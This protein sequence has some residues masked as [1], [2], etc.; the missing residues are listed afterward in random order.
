MSEVVEI[1][2]PAKNA[3]LTLEQAQ[4]ITR[5]H[6]AEEIAEL[7][8]KNAQFIGENEAELE[9]YKGI[10]KELELRRE[11]LTVKLTKIIQGEGDELFDT[12]ALRGLQEIA[13]VPHW[14]AR[15][16][17][18]YGGGL[19]LSMP[20]DGC[21]V[22]EGGRMLCYLVRSWPD[23]TAYPAHQL[24]HLSTEDRNGLLKAGRKGA[25]AGLVVAATATDVNVVF[26]LPW[27]LLETA[28]PVKWTDP[29]LVALGSARDNIL[30]FTEI[31]PAR[32]HF[33]RGR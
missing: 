32:R 27:S 30:D 25:H 10:K 14:P 1:R 29:A 3:G 5:Y 24:E 20:Y 12:V 22:V 11:M 4:I 6:K 21:G 9:K 33:E 18:P 7:L 2:V 16:R 8:E 19:N 28:H 26:W 31:M 23:K 15:V 17:N 13:Y